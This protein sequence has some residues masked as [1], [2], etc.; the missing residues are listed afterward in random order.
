MNKD[1]QR[2]LL[3]LGLAVAIIGGIL[4]IVFMS[5]SPATNNGTVDMPVADNE[6]SLGNKDSDIVLV[7]YSDLQ[8]PACAAREPQV[9]QLINEFGS[10][11]RF[12][13][14]HFP[15]RNNHPNAQI[16]A[17]S[18]EA[19][20]M[21]KK[22]WEM[23]DI[24]FEKQDEWAGESNDDAK[25]LFIGYAKELGLDTAKFAEDMESDEAEDAVNA[26]QKSGVQAGVNS[27][28]TFYLNGKLINATSYEDLRNIIKQSIDSA[29]QEPTT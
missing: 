17:Q 21:Q 11:I 3:W 2:L 23:H 16:S 25:K 5:G 6:W 24:L 13:Y 4:A 20:G 12:V 18:A 1:I 29:K 15:L 22:F 8:C 14:R 28:P 10:H 9:K 27:T 7:E 19:A 26:D